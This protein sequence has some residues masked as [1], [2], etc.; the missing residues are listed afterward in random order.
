[1]WGKLI[2]NV[3]HSSL[4]FILHKTIRNETIRCVNIFSIVFNI[5]TV[6]VLHS[7]S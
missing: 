7:I 5:P 1:M 6:L 4:L 3:Q 2:V